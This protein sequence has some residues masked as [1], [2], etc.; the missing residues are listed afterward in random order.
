MEETDTTEVAYIRETSRS[1]P[2]R[3]RFHLRDYRQTMQRA[4]RRGGEPRRQAG[5]REEEEPEETSS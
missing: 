2:S 5:A 4:Q 1:L 3:I